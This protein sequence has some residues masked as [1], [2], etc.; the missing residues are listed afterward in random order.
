MLKSCPQCK[1]Q[2]SIDEFH[3]SAAWADGRYPWCKP[4]RKTKSKEYYEN[5][6]DKNLQRVH[7]YRQ[8]NIDTVREKDKIRSSIRNQS[9]ATK[10]YKWS[11]Q[12]NSKYGIDVNQYRALLDSQDGKC[13]I[14]GKTPEQEGRR[15]AVEHDHGTREI[16]GLCCWSCNYRLLGRIRNPDLYRKAAEY[17]EKGTGLFVPKKK[18][19]RTMKVRAPRKERTSRGI[20]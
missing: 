1:E 15:L 4:C 16:M 19:R 6:R 8:L 9:E 7:D 20:K 2:K 3:L 17:L 10:E 18:R 13:A 12:L 11:Q 5:N 14:C